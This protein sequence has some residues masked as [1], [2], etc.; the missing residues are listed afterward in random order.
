MSKYAIIY[1]ESY[2]AAGY[3]S[4]DSSYTAYYDTIM[5]FETEDALIK[6]I[7]DEDSRAYGK[8]SYRVIRFDDV[9]VNKSISFELSS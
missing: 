5:E 6:W 3:D 7:T 8:K 2:T 4:R 1:K 9:K